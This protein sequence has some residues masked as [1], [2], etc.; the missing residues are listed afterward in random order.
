MA[1]RRSLRID[2]DP[3]T[4]DAAVQAALAKHIEDGA[5]EVT[6]HEPAHRY[7][8]GWHG[9]LAAAR[10]RFEIEEL[11]DQSDGTTAVE[12]HATLWLGGVLG[13]LHA[14]VRWRGNRNHLD[15][16]LESMKKRTER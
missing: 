3:H 11:A 4:V 8:I 15:R 16:L 14:L 12:L 10:Y 13:P 6:E 1:I 7:G 2:R 5:Y 9:P